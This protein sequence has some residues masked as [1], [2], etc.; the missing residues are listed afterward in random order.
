MDNYFEQSVSGERG[1]REQF[2]YGLCSAAGIVLA[3]AALFALTGVVSIGEESFR[4]NWINIGIVVAAGALAALAFLSRDKVYCDY[5]Y[6]LWNSELEVC[7]VY[8]RKRRKK[9]GTI[10]LNR[11]SAWGPAG[12]MAN[13]VNNV[14]KQKWCVREDKAWCLVY[15]GEGGTQAVLLELSEEML[16]Q[17]RMT[18]RNLRNTE[19]RS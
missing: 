18:E 11:V 10:P 6:I 16:A 7:A 15:P 8:N 13:R 12:A 9:T 19:V 14:K 5:D 2:L 4:V 3:I 17:M 1:P